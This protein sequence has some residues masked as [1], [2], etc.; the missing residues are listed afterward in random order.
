MTTLGSANATVH[1]RGNQSLKRAPQGLP[2]YRS[3]HSICSIF[4]T[5]QAFRFKV[6]DSPDCHRRSDQSRATLD[7]VDFVSR[8]CGNASTGA[9]H[10][11]RLYLAENSTRFGFLKGRFPA[12]SKDPIRLAADY[13]LWH[14]GSNISFVTSFPNNASHQLGK[15]IAM[16]FR[17]MVLFGAPSSSTDGYTR[18][19]CR[20]TLGQC[21]V[22]I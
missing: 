17:S 19:L 14:G 16:R 2:I 22:C 12:I 9:E 6:K 21:G 10:F 4:S 3:S 13:C 8:V 20:T 18:K 15:G 11:R 7:D 5:E 1:E